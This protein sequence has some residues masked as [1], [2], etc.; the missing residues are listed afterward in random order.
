MVGLVGLTVWAGAGFGDEVTA[1]ADVAT[2]QQKTPL[3]PRPRLAAVGQLHD[4]VG[5]G[6]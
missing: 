2:H 5:A 4:I 6:L 1:A 3:A